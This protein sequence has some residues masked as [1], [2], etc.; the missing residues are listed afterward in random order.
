MKKDSWCYMKFVKKYK[1][2]IL[3]LI[4]P[5]IIL[6]IFFWLMGCFSEKIILN[7]DMHDQYVSLFSYLKNL[8]HGDATFPYSFSKGLGG[9]MYGSFFYYLSSPLNLLVYFAKDITIFLTIL[10][11]IKLSLCSF[12]MNLF[13]SYKFKKNNIEIFV[14][15]FIYALIG[16]N[17]NY[18]T[19]IMWLDSVI[20][21]PIIL[22]GIDKI[23]NGKSD[24]T[25]IVTLFLA[26][27]SNYYI[28]YMLCIIS[29]IYFLYSLFLKNEIKNN[30]KQ[31]IK[32]IRH[33]F[34]ITI[35]IGLMT[36]FILIPSGLELLNTERIYGLSSFKPINFNFFD[37][38][39]PFYIGFGNLQNPLNYLG[40]N[41]YCGVLMIPL[42]VLYFKNSKISKKEKVLT[43]IVYLILL[44]PITFTF[45]NYIWHMFTI[46]IAFNFRYSFFASLFTIYIAVKSYFNLEVNKKSLIKTFTIILIFSASLIF[47]CSSTP[48]YYLYLK[49]YKILLS[50]VFLVVYICLLLK[51]KYKIA[52]FIVFFEVILNMGVIGYESDMI[53]KYIYNLETERLNNFSIVCEE[54]FRCESL[55][56]LT[57]NDALFSNYN[58]I[59]YFLTTANKGN[60]QFLLN[61]NG[62]K[63]KRNF[64]SYIASNPV[65]EMLTGVE[66]IQSRMK[67][68]DYEIVSSIVMNDVDIYTYKNSRSL[69]LGY[70]VSSKLK[71]FYTNEIGIFY[72]EK[73]LN[74]MLDNNTKYFYELNS[75]K[76]NDLEYEI[77]IDFDSPYI[78]VIGPQVLTLNNEELTLNEAIY[79]NDG[80]GGGYNIIYNKYLDNIITLKFRT[81]PDDINTYYIDIEKLDNFYSEI[82]KNQLV[83]IEKVGNYIKGEILNNEKGILFTTIP[84]EKGWTI[85]VNGEKVEYFKV[86]DGFIGIELNQ[87]KYLIELEYSIYGLKPGIIISIF[88]MIGIVCYQIFL[89]QKR[90][91]AGVDLIGFY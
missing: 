88:A 12:A 63:T 6:I 14:F 50:L 66:Y 54:S 48:E 23:I 29:I 31:I 11:I 7:S 20:L 24:W 55:I 71:D 33:F 30:K 44:L 9:G 41:I 84:Y 90:K 42:V 64:Y 26:I 5:L 72:Q 22:I 1:W 17:I 43:S 18:Y 62:I 61:I 82:S 15:S 80:D 39:A 4:V 32:E 38:I 60:M 16:Y 2:N 8:L 51:N 37:Y 21:L 65:L 87:G 75:K 70:I 45:L 13:L 47:L 27:F 10:V 52:V 46:P 67:N 59:T 35:L 85:K 19:N 36:S 68:N 3:S 69:S 83:V 53:K 86:V 77:K 49:W 91:N 25:Y 57:G 73:L 81:E 28:G 76:I 74:Y 79:I 34:L 78:Y 89:K 40:F 58:G 56:K